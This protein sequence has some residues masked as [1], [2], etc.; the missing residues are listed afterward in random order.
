MDQLVT[1]LRTFDGRFVRIRVGTSEGTAV[2]EM[3]GVLREPEWSSDGLARE[4]EG[5]D[6]RPAIW[7]SEARLIEIRRDGLIA[8]SRGLEVRIDVAE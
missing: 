5:T 6:P 1:A 4:L 8:A 2:A 3:A 7:L